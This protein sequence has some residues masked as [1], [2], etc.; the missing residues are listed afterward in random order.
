MAYNENTESGLPEALDAPYQGGK[1]LGKKLFGI[2]EEGAGNKPKINTAKADQERFLGLESRGMQGEYAALLRAQMAGKG[3][4]IAQ[5]QFASNR[6]AAIRAGT[7]A[8][9][10]AR[11]AN[12]ALAGRS[13]AQQAGRGA[14]TGARDAATLRAQEQLAAQQQYGAL[15][16]AQRQQDL[17]ARGYSIDEARAQL[18]ADSSYANNLTQI[19]EGNAARGQNPAGIAVG[20]LGGLLSDIRAKENVQAIGGFDLGA[21]SNPMT[22]SQQQQ[23]QAQQ[24]QMMA[25]QQQSL[26]AQPQA[27]QQAAPGGGGGFLDSIM[28]GGG[29][30]FLSDARVKEE[31]AALK[32]ALAAQTQPG[33]T[34]SGGIGAGAG[35]V[36]AGQTFSQPAANSPEAL[37]KQMMGAN[38]MG[39]APSYAGLNAMSPQQ[40]AAPGQPAQSSNFLSSFGQW[41]AGN[42]GLQ[43]GMFPSDARLKEENAA[44]RSV[45]ASRGGAVAGQLA[46]SPVVAASAQQPAFSFNYTPEAQRAYGLSPEPQVGT[47]TQAM[48]QNPLYRSAVKKDQ[49][50]M[51]RVDT[52]QVA[53]TGVA[54]DSE[55]SRQQLRQAQELDALKNAVLT[56]LQ[57]GGG[58]SGGGGGGKDG[59]SKTPPREKRIKYREKV[60]FPPGA[61]VKPDTRPPGSVKE[62]NHPKATA[63]R[64]FGVHEE[65]GLNALRR[66]KAAKSGVE[67][68]PFSIPEERMLDAVRL[69]APSPPA[70][71]KVAAS[72]RFKP[73]GSRPWHQQKSGD[74]ARTGDNV[75]SAPTDV[76]WPSPKLSPTDLLRSELDPQSGDIVTDPNSGQRY[77]RR[78]AGVEHEDDGPA[79]RNIPSAKPGVNRFGGRMQTPQGGERVPEDWLTE[80]GRVDKPTFEDVQG[81]IA[82]DISQME[83][84]KDRQKAIR[85]FSD[86]VA[87]E[88]MRGDQLSPST[89]LNN[90]KKRGVKVSLKEVEDALRVEYNL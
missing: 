7:A 56:S 1:F 72:A 62:A 18:Q 36:A 16:Q 63:E 46:Q 66:L 22:Q 25:A 76:L 37:D 67:Q 15:A 42:M 87:G 10:S 79:Y 51:G 3:P 81:D 78:Y 35:G 60:P 33:S 85:T 71:A 28:G 70:S 57:G 31:N 75:A 44:L 27:Q 13:A 82:S 89:I 73:M 90:L 86:F 19:S 52:D 6:D 58:G 65:E 74:W 84:G 41:G 17:L 53:M 83:A 14:M 30:G 49:N 55:L 34:P 40:S 50:G 2:N 45:L 20:A 4:S 32:A 88:N 9:A 77:L 12:T 80:S 5:A 68:E 59:K 21:S 8:A 64:G 48:E 23:M 43:P 26:S 47:V 69:G 29:G 11:G 39:M 24:Q 61:P 38:N 54:V